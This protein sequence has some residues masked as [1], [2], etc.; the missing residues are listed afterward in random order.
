VFLHFL[1]LGVSCSD[2]SFDR[3]SETLVREPV[4]EV[5]LD[6]LRFPRWNILV[7][8][9]LVETVHQLGRR[10]GPELWHTDV[11]AIAVAW[12]IAHHCCFLDLQSLPVGVDYA[13][14]NDL[15][16]KLSVRRE[17]RHCVILLVK[18][19]HVD[20]LIANVCDFERFLE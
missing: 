12:R 2:L 10:D 6:G 14:E 1:G 16:G 4:L 9:V 7:V 15:D 8:V 18:Y 19:S 13:L 17:L 3:V 5:R 20:M 11:E